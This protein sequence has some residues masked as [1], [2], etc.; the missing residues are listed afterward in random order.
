MN[1]PNRMTQIATM[2]QSPYSK[3]STSVR[4]DVLL[5]IYLQH[6]YLVQKHLQSIRTRLLQKKPTIKASNILIRYILFRKLY[7]NDAA[8]LLRRKTNACSDKIRKLPQNRSD[9]YAEASK[10][11]RATWNRCEHA[12]YLNLF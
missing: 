12:A 8:T 3:L 10:Q 7:S 4:A 9:S 1:T 11:F 5:E 6:I 2:I